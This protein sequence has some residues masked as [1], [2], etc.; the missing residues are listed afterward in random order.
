MEAMALQGEVEVVQA[1]A[2]VQV[3]VLQIKESLKMK[4][5]ASKA[6]L[7]TLSSWKILPMLPTANNLHSFYWHRLPRLES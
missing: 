2:V 4:D 5:S 1:V 3:V 6:Q 7:P